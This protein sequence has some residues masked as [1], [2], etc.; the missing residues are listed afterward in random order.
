MVKSTWPGVSMMLMRCPMPFVRA[1]GR[2]PEAVRRGRRDR[3]AALL[4]LDHPVHGRG[5]VVDLAHLVVDARVIEDPLGHRGLARIDVGH[6]PDVAR[7]LQGVSRA[8]FVLRVVES[9]AVAG[10]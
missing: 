1:L 2:R 3:D 4:L 8:T 7:S 10:F 9:G 5:A 6:D